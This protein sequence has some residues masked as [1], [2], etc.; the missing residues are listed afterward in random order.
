DGLE[1]EIKE[2]FSMPKSMGKPRPRL[3]CN[4]YY[5][6]GDMRFIKQEREI[7]SQETNYEPVFLRLYMRE[8]KL[9]EKGSN[10][11]LEN[12]LKISLFVKM[13]N[14][15]Y[16]QIK[17]AYNNHFDI[18]SEFSDYP[19]AFK[20]NIRAYGNQEKKAVIET[21]NILNHVR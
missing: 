1:N 7:S 19:S 5:L 10:E 2:K 8:K 3:D 12:N 18:Y 9:L 16:T 21:F 15:R 11:E 14:N 6:N 4:E 17:W 20:I 13:L